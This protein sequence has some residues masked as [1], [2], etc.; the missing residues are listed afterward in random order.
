MDILLIGSTGSLM[1]R[2]VEKLYKEGHRI[3][4]LTEE[5]KEIPAYRK[6]FETYRFSYDNACIREVFVSVKPEVT[7]FLGAFDRNFHWNTSSNTSVKY[8]SGL[9]N[10]LMSFAALRRGRFVYLSSEQ[11]FSDLEVADDGEIESGKNSDEKSQ[12]IAMG[13]K[14]C[15]EYGKMTKGDVAVLRLGNLYGIPENVDELD[16]ICARM[17]LDAMDLGE[18]RLSAGKSMVVHGVAPAMDMQNVDFQVLDEKEVTLLFLQDAVEYIYMIMSTKLLHSQVYQISGKTSVSFNELAKLVMSGIAAVT[19]ETGLDDHILE[20]VQKTESNVIFSNLEF[21]REFSLV[22]FNPPSKAVPLVAEYIKKN[23]DKFSRRPDRQE[24]LWRRIRKT[25]NELFRAAVPFMENLVAFIPFFML[26][27][28]AVGSQYFHRIDFYVLYVLLFAVVH[29][30]QQA[31]FSSLL[32]IAGFC[33]RQMY[34]RTGFEVMLDYNTYVWMA[35]LLILGLVVGYMKDRLK[36]IRDE[37]AGEVDFLT[38]QLSDISDI[39]ESNVRVKDVLSDQ[40]VNQNDS[41]GKIYEITSELDQHE[42]E[43]VLFYAA[44]VV[45]KIMHSKDVAIYSMANESY[46]RLFS[47]TSEKSR[48]LGNSVNITQM[49]KMYRVLQDR[50]VYINKN[51]EEGYPLMA[52]ALYENDQIKLIV[53]VWG[54]SWERMT[55]GQA[56]MLAVASSLI[57]NAVLRANR[58]IDMLQSSRYIGETRIMEPEAFEQMVSAFLK[59][60][61]KGLTVCTLVNIDTEGRDIYTMDRILGELVRNTDYIGSTVD[62]GIQILL[63]N[64]G[65]KASAMVVDR[66]RQAGLSCESEEE[67][68]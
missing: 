36:S 52:N 67:E 41:L 34:N 50:R 59:A 5:G 46:A 9:M 56:N 48:S 19:K 3:F 45:A 30:Q 8:S 40:L 16:N 51:M 20:D 47:A 39:N 38:R 68:V 58:Y 29:G 57:Q 7:L 65:I 17:C 43:E 42:R 66:F 14:I 44:E 6:V 28:R 15:L 54:I 26:N 53:M 63:A 25:V 2:M 21:D 64:S 10:I 35:Q 24:S 32:A 22:E 37:N 49:D 27:N 62:G 12:S 33:F 13:E 18:I 4:V 31:I 61:K 1:R 55:L 11:V 23:E 60:R